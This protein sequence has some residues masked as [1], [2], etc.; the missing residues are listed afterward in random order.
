LAFESA[1]EEVETKVFPFE[2]NCCYTLQIF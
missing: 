1:A 2:L